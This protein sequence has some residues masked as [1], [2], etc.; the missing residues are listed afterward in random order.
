MP[1]S[2]SVPGSGNRSNDESPPSPLAQVS[3]PGI[4]ATKVTPPCLRDREWRECQLHN[5]RRM[6]DTVGPPESER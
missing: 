4:V 1:S 2:T 6:K 3:Y 5:P